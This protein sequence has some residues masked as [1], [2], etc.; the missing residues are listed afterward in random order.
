MRSC[1]FPLFRRPRPST[2]SSGFSAIHFRSGRPHQRRNEFFSAQPNQP[3]RKRHGPAHVRGQLHV[4]QGRG[5]T[6]QPRLSTLP[7]G[8]PGLLPADQYVLE[9]ESGPQN[10]EPGHVQEVLGLRREGSKPL[11]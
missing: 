5:E 8:E 4:F 2:P 9:A 3:K 6:G 1:I 10:P 11:A 7:E